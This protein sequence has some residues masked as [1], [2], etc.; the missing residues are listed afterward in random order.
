M[1][2]S[3]FKREVERGMLL[4]GRC[5]L[6]SLSGRALGM[7][8]A[9]RPSFPLRARAAIFG[10][11]AQRERSRSSEFR[12]VVFEDVMFEHNIGYLIIKLVLI[13]LMLHI[14]PYDDYYDQTP[15]PQTPHP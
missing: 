9:H 8:S 14:K 11:R 10:G 5:R 2:R 13:K 6:V 4:H 3:C 15:H 12:D 7:A 1:V